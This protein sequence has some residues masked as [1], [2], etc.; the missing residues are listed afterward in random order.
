M[1]YLCTCM[2]PLYFFSS[3][4]IRPW[5]RGTPWGCNGGVGPWSADQDDK[6][7]QTVCVGPGTV[8][9]CAGCMAAWQSL[10][11]DCMMAALCHDAV[12]AVLHNN[13]TAETGSETWLE[14]QHTG[15]TK[16]LHHGDVM[17]CG[18]RK[19]CGIMWP[20]AQQLRLLSSE[21]LLTFHLK[22]QNAE[23]CFRLFL[24]EA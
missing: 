3:W 2:H 1:Y 13:A 5:W 23:P 4:S 12:T 16:E 7:W 9:P 24:H 8:E 22:Y 20:W 19:N 6:I 18:L 11:H 17:S 10:W 14:L 15:A 21:L